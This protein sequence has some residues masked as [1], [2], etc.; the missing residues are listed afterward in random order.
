MIYG[1]GIWGKNPEGLVFRN[2]EV[3]EFDPV[4]LMKQGCEPKAG[5][6]LG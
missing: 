6:D 4:G 3:K 1:L 5:A 2:W